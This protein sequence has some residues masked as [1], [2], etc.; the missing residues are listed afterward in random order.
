MQSPMYAGFDMSEK[1]AELGLIGK[2]GELILE[3]KRFSNNL[4]GARAIETD[5]AQQAKAYSADALLIAT[6]AT[7]FFDWHLLEF[8]AQSTLLAPYCPQIYRLNPK[9]VKRYKEIDSETDKTDTIDAIAI[10]DRVRVRVP[11]HRFNAN[12]DYLPLQR[13]TR[14]RAHLARQI[15][16]EKNYFLAHLFLKFSAFSA[17]EP[18]SNTFGATATA[19][20]EEFFSVDQLAETG[21]ETLLK[22]VVKHRKNRFTAPEGVVAKLEQVA[23]ESYR[24]RPELSKSVNLVLATTLNNIRAL[25]QSLVEV[26]A[27]I[28]TALN[29]FELTLATIPGIGPTYCAGIFAEI[30]DI[31]RFSKEASLARYAGLAWRKHQSGDFEADET[32]M[33]RSSNKYLRYYLVE[34]ANSVR[35]HE[36]SYQ[37]YYR[38]KYN[39]VSRHQHKRALVLTARKLVR[40]IY[41]LLKNGQI[42]QQKKVKN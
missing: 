2:T 34:A 40:L 41:T 22:F 20:V 27:A 8:L 16:D 13:L 33:M 36:V 23:R 26:N 38:K 9:W 28:E 3:G 25:K 24:I 29:G 39:E 12:M 6:E 14:F 21:V 30:G 11:K 5:L 10:A 37:A 4:S 31:D 17:V 35:N 15:A 18:F 32:P 1:H 7:S 19:V 42:Y